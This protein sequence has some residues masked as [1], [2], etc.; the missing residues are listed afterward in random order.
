MIEHV[1]FAGGLAH[2]HAKYT[3]IYHVLRMLQGKLTSVGAP[4]LQN[5]QANH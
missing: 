3:I 5:N 4:L 1:H 2:G